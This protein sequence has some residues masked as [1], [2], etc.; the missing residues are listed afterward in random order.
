MKALAKVTL[1]LGLVWAL[2]ARA[3]AHCEVPCGIYD[4]ALRVR[5]IREDLATIE[6]AMKQIVALSKAPDRNANQLAR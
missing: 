2:G 5:V 6:K 3:R 4:D 1:A